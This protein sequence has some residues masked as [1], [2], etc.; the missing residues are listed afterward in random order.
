MG[1]VF[2]NCVRAAVLVPFSEKSL[3]L[4]FQL[5]ISIF[6]A[7]QVKNVKL[8]SEAQHKGLKSKYLQLW[9]EWVQLEPPY[10][11]TI[12]GLLTAIGH[13]RCCRWPISWILGPKGEKS[14]KMTKIRVSKGLKSKYLQLWTE[15][16]IRTPETPY[17][18]SINGLL[19]DT[20]WKF[21]QVKLKPWFLMSAKKLMPIHR[22]LPLETSI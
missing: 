11:L 2:K 1:G 5:K 12:N 22:L 21:Q 10:R 4:K 3:C 20:V 7:F 17:I 16:S 8:T 18:L 14:I 15:Y 6:Q 19:T 9:A 13:L